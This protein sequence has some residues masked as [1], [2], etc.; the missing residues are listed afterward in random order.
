MC[1]CTVHCNVF[2][3]I[4]DSRVLGEIALVVQLSLHWEKESLS[5]SLRALDLNGYFH[6]STLGIRYPR[7]VSQ[8]GSTHSYTIGSIL[9]GSKSLWL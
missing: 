8:L 1:N 3:I 2:C 6:F 5:R 4:P 9:C 7:V